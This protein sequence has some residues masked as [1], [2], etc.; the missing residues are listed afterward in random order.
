[1]DK[2]NK[3][4]SAAAS[5][6]SAH[7]AQSEHDAECKYCAA[8]KTVNDPEEGDCPYCARNEAPADSLASCK[9]CAA[10]ETPGA[11]CQYCNRPEVSA[12]A[13]ECKYCAGAEQTGPAGVPCEYCAAAPVAQNPTTDS[14][15]YE[16]QDLDSP[17]MP[18]PQPGD[19]PPILAAPAT[20]VPSNNNLNLDGQGEV[21]VTS[22]QPKEGV[23]L[24]QSKEALQA[25]AQEIE[26]AAS[27]QAAAQNV[28]SAEL[29]V[30]TEMDGNVS[31]PGGYGANTPGD[32]GLNEANEVE[33]EPDMASVLSEGLDAHADNIQRERVIQMVSSALEGFKAS[34][35][36]IERAQE[37]A[38]QLY[39]SSIMMLKAMIEMA[40]MLGLDSEGAPAP[41]GNPLDAPAQ[42][43][44]PWH[45]PFPAHPEN[46]G[47]A[48]QATPVAAP[49]GQEN[50]WS[51]PFPVHP[52][53][54]GGEGRIGQ[55]V[56]KLPTSATTQHVPKVPIQ[57]GSVNA[58]G[59][60]RYV[61]PKTEKESFIDMKEG[62]VLSPTG[63]PVKPAQG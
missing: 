56:G 3:E 24:D 63:K 14:Q 13:V 44:N 15:N 11:D 59:Q 28:D 51:N 58:N 23:Q 1:M 7:M 41:E 60:M 22:D 62:R 10:S 5:A 42:P 32:M 40:K 21:T 29:A 47:Q 17:A 16:G 52:E 39:Q 30:G 57:P 61:D 27:P 49:A 12:E 2:M 9:Y 19:G 50:S 55:G 4:A 48:P 31:R 34:K 35:Q 53:N 54:G 46:G 45:E 8:L 26:G 36:I 6:G 38:P 33:A 37:Q 43:E 25:I 20:D 18:K